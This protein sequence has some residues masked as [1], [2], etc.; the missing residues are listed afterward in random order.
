MQYILTQEEYD[1]LLS[2]KPEQLQDTMFDLVKAFLDPLDVRSSIDYSVP[3]AEKEVI[4]RVK[5]DDI[6]PEIINHLAS[7]GIK[8]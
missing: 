7:K 2:G 8:L 5:F 4:F 1:N 6:H 3:F